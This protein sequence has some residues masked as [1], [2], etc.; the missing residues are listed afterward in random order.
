MLKLLKVS[1]ES[2]APD[3]QEGDFVVIVKI[4]FLMRRLHSGDVVVFR[5]PLYGVLIKKVETLSKDRQEVFLTGTHTN[6]LDSRR[7]GAVRV[8]SLLGKVI[9]HIRKPVPN[10][11]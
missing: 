2:L 9:W 10:E 11:S 6:S 4:P 3:Y 1:G 8:S 5:H 7:F